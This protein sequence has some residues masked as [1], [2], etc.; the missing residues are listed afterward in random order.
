M[1]LSEFIL[2]LVSQVVILIVAYFG[3]KGK[4]AELGN[5][6]K[7]VQKDASEAKEAAV[8]TE[9]S[10][11]NRPTPLSD[12]MDEIHS[13]AKNTTKL[14]EDALSVLERHTSELNSVRSE[15]ALTNKELV[16]MGGQVRGV[17]DEVI[18]LKKDDEQTR[19]VVREAISDR[20]RRLNH[21]RAEIPRIIERQLKSN[22]E[23][24]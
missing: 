24:D 20:D 1:G 22:G 21:L 16:I 18:Q 12:R 17:R 2:G 11:N 23:S 19:E 4:L 8:K 6:L 5:G 14:V 10:I 9:S 15:S 3:L 7:T 13:E